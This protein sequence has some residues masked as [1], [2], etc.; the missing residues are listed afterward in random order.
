MI[1]FPTLSANV[2]KDEGSSNQVEPPKKEKLPKKCKGAKKY[3]TN[4]EDVLDKV[5]TE[6][7][8]SKKTNDEVTKS[9]KDGSRIRTT[10]EMKDSLEPKMPNFDDDM[11]I[12]DEP[13]MD[14]N[15]EET[16]TNPDKY[17]SILLMEPTFEKKKTPTPSTTRSN[18]TES[19]SDDETMPGDSPPGVI[20]R[21]VI[22]SS[23]ARA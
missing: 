15:D 23:R 22:E 4:N 12:F 20:G 9:D 8:E 6:S 3:N 21:G 5:V 13:K 19:S 7:Y 17:V 18:R 11:T 2:D 10:L 14:D 1:N 16:D